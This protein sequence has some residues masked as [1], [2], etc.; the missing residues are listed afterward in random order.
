MFCLCVDFHFLLLSYRAS[1]SV[2]FRVP[3]QPQIIL[4]NR[5][6]AENI[7]R[8]YSHS[9]NLHPHLAIYPNRNLPI[10][11]FITILVRHVF[12]VVWYQRIT[13]KQLQRPGFREKAKLVH[14]RHHGVQH[15][16]LKRSIRDAVVFHLK[17]RSSRPVVRDD[18]FRDVFD[19][20]DADDKSVAAGARAFHLVRFDVSRRR[21]GQFSSVLLMSTPKIAPARMKRNRVINSAKK[22]R[23]N[24]YSTPVVPRV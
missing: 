23:A 22:K 18:P 7:V 21:K 13:H 12:H 9:D 14:L 19:V 10:V 20:R 1:R 3:N 2:P 24:A 4:L 5:G 8:V 6:Y 16:V 11:R 17:F 15:F